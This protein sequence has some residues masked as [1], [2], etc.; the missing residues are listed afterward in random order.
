MNILADILISIIAWAHR[1]FRMVI[2]GCFIVR[3]IM[4]TRYTPSF[5]ILQQ[6]EAFVDGARA[7]LKQGGP[8]GI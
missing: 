8:W 1:G 6:L 3:L 7:T 2:L 4:F 5:F